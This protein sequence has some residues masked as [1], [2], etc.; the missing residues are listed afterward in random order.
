M[1][2]Q[3][4]RLVDSFMP[5]LNKAGCAELITGLLAMVTE[6]TTRRHRV[7]LQAPEKQRRQTW[8]LSLKRLKSRWICIITPSPPVSLLPPSLHGVLIRCKDSD[9]D[10]PIARPSLHRKHSTSYLCTLRTKMKLLANFKKSPTATVLRYL[11][12]QPGTSLAPPG[13]FPYSQPEFVSNVSRYKGIWS[14]LPNK[15]VW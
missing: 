10:I 12:K 11:P 9:A 13:C 14:Y 5:Q 3:A 4:M 2:P 7:S 1:L 6:F 15:F 8:T